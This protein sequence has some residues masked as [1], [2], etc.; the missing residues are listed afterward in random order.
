MYMCYSARGRRPHFSDIDKLSSPTQDLYHH[1][2][3][4]TTTSHQFLLHTQ[5][6]SLPPRNRSQRFSLVFFLTSPSAG[7]ASVRNMGPS[8]LLQ[9][10]YG[11]CERTLL[12]PS[13]EIS[14]AE[15]KRTLSNDDDLSEV[16]L[17]SL[18]PA[19]RPGLKRASKI[20]RH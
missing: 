3:L 6:P 18:P 2:L 12:L 20:H 9:I 16:G 7:S 10:T 13:F 11:L 4:T 8:P 15:G 1:H 19:P 17:Q 14:G 5:Q